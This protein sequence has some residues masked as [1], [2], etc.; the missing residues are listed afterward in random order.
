MTTRLNA[1][2]FFG[3]AWWA[4]MTNDNA[5]IQGNKTKE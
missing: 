1:I 5:A 3:L 4:M 2:A